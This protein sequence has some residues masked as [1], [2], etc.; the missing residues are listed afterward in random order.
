MGAGAAAKGGVALA[1]AGVSIGANTLEAAAF[2]FMKLDAGAIKG[3]K[4]ADEVNAMMS[5]ADGWSPAWQTGTSVAE[6]TV[7][8]G[9]TVQMVVGEK[10]YRA[11]ERGDVSEAFG[12]WATFDDVPN[13]AYAGNELAM[14]SALTGK[15]GQLYVVEIQVTKSINAQVGLVGAQGAAPG[16]GNQLHFF[17]PRD[18][19]SSIFKYV[20][21]SG[22]SL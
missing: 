10:A 22:R 20:A 21:N 16:G 3:F 1:Q 6:V 12:G 14:T 13:A 4:S 7:K 5:A 19:R 11:M 8:P 2:Q 15:A 17:V 9:T 18:S